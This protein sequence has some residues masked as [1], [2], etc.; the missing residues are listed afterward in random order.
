MEHSTMRSC[1][2]IDY[3][4]K[5]QEFELAFKVKEEVERHVCLSGFLYKVED[6]KNIIPAPLFRK[7]ETE[8]TTYMSIEK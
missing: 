1:N 6:L 8:V 5:N 7:M 4:K 2:V 3:L